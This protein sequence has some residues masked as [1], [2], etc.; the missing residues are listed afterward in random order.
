MDKLN[1]L[2]DLNIIYISNANNYI[3]KKMLKV[4]IIIFIL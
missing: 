2:L 3:K 4:Y 1:F